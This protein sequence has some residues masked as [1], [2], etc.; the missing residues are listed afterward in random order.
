MG[1][2]TTL[3]AKVEVTGDVANLPLG[4]LSLTA[5]SPT[6]TVAV[7]A[8]IL[9]LFSLLQGGVAFPPSDTDVTGNLPQ[10]A[11]A[12]TGLTPSATLSTIR[13]P[14]D[15]AYGGGSAVFGFD[16]PHTI[17]VP[18]PV[19]VYLPTLHL[20]L[21]SGHVSA[22]STAHQSSHV[23]AFKIKIKRKKLKAHLSHRH[24]TTLQPQVLMT[25]GPPP[26][27]LVD[28]R[29]FAEDEFLCLIH[30]L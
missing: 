19:E 9:D 21:H 27:I 6:A 17:I 15:V 25:S 4:A 13:A 3:R 5:L 10:G 8:G 23:P 28:R 29:T 11:L 14:M 12:L 1:L 16:P 30:S 26:G 20:T 24:F 18:V 22:Q 2:L 7:P